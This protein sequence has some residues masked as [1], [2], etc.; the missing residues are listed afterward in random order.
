MAQ[1]IEQSNTA[2]EQRDK[3]RLEI[4]AIDQANKKEQENFDKQM[5]EMGRAL[6]AE[7]NAAAERRKSQHP[8]IADADEE[9]KIAAE[10]A[11]KENAL[12]KEKEARSKERQEKVQQFEDAFHRI[13]NATGVSDVDELVQR[14]A[15]NDEQNFSLFKFANEQANEITSLEEQVEGLHKERSELDANKAPEQIEEHSKLNQ[16][17]NKISEA[18]RQIEKLTEKTTECHTELDSIQDGLKVSHFC[19]F[20]C[21]LNTLILNI[22]ISP[23][24]P[25]QDVNHP[26]G[27]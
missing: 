17:D 23:P 9:S 19:F 27:L 8:S 15:K 1:V 24:I 26:A 12:L 7:I 13:E 4:V 3:S 20:N 6:E 14:F 2:Y 5:E 21:F 10:K 18:S 25:R 22:H 16:I 11:A